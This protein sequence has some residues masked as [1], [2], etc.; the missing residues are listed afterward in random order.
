M[1]FVNEDG[2]FAHARHRHKREPPG[3]S[4]HATQ[5]HWIARLLHAEAAASKQMASLGSDFQQRAIGRR[6][7]ESIQRKD[8]KKRLLRCQKRWR[9]SERRATMVLFGLRFRRWRSRSWRRR[10]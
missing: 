4:L 5:D 1:D 8:V 6:L 3:K 7:T 2:G 10:R 9:A